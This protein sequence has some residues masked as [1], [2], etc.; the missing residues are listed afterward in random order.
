[1]NKLITFND[2]PSLVKKIKSQGKT[3]TLVGGCFD[4]LHYGH[5]EFLEKAKNQGNVLFV[6]LESDESIKKRKGKNRPIHSQIDRA[7]ILSSVKSVDYILLLP[8]LKTDL[9]YY[10][11]VKSIEPD[12]IAVTEKDPAY[13]NKVEQAE[14]VGGKVVEVVSLIPNISTKE[15]I[16][17]I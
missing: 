10:N 9:E 14:M 13:N 12:I 15:L 16:E 3:I 2:I 4:I 7:N 6:M 5:L 17:R 11:L 8:H 1:M